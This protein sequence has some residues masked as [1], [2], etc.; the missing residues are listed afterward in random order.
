ML[1]PDGCLARSVMRTQPSAE[2]TGAVRTRQLKTTNEK[3]WQPVLPKKMLCALDERPANGCHRNSAN[4]LLKLVRRR[5]RDR[6]TVTEP[7]TARRTG[8]RRGRGR[9]I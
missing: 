1:D 2:E 6:V 9:S 7:F 3:N 4:L 8:S 5:Q